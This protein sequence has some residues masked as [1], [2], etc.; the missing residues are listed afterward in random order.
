MNEYQQYY[1]QQLAPQQLGGLAPQGFFGSLLGAPLGGLI[2][3]GIGGL[4]G[5]SHLGSQIGQAAGGIGGSF[6]PLGVDPVTAAYAQQAQQQQLQQLQQAQLAP[7]G[8]FGNIIKSVAQPLGGAIGGAFGNAGLGNTIGGIAGQLGG[9]LP[10][11]ADPVQQAYAQQAAQLQQLQQLQAQGLAPQGW[12]GNIIK[13]VAQPLGGAIGGAFGNAGLGNTIGGIAGQLG[14]MLPF[15]AD[16]VAQA[17]AQQA[18]QLQQLQAQGLAPQGWFGNI[19]KSVAQPLGGA[20]GGAFGNA[21]LGNT[22]G[23]IAGQLGGMLP[24]SAD[25]VTQAYAQQAAQLQAQGLAPQGFFNDLLRNRANTGII[26]PPIFSRPIGSPGIG[27]SSPNIASMLPFAVDPVTQAY[28]QQAQDAQLQGLAPQG[29]FGNIIKSVAQPLGGAIGGAFGNAGL[30]NTIGG[31][32]G[33]LGGM[34]PFAA[35][36]VTAAYAQQQLQQQLQQQQQQQAQQA[37][38]AQLTQQAQM[39]NAGNTAL[40]GGQ[41]LH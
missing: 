13:S 29:W 14:G 25:P 22:I 8:W 41:L 1:G 23:G 30:G 35:D 3:R 4:F 31:I 16:P 39:A 20:I 38:L 18:A 37:Q 32:A 40:Y 19:I 7:Q 10:F 15:S 33:Q 36:P 17:Y 21:G 27:Y 5:N 2:G 12:F 24:F 9:M 34:L 28:A 6:L 11:A 26:S